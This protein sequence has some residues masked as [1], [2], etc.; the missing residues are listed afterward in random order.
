MCLTCQRLL[1]DAERV[2]FTGSRFGLDFPLRIEPTVYAFASHLCPTY[3]GGYWEFY[4]LSNGGFYMAPS[5]DGPVEVACPTGFTGR[6]TSSAF[7]ITVCLYAFSHLSF[8][9]SESIATVCADHYHLLREHALDHR[10]A[11]SILAATD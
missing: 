5:D 7:G 8:S 11:S 3:S 9:D 4:A 1:D 2:A 10:E 6:L